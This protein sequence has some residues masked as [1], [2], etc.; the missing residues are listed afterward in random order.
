MGTELKKTIYYIVYLFIV[1]GIILCGFELVSYYLLTT[2]NKKTINKT[3]IIDPTLV[4]ASNPDINEFRDKLAE[5]GHQYEDGFTIYNAKDSVVDDKSRIKIL[6]L[7]GSTS[8]SIYYNQKRE[9][10]LNWPEYFARL[11]KEKGHNAIVINGSIAGYNSTQELLKL[12]RDG[13]E[14]SPD[15]IIEFG[16]L[17][18]IDSLAPLPYPMVLEHQRHIAKLT[19]NNMKDDSKASYFFMKNTI[20]LLKNTNKI[21]Y[22]LTYGKKSNNNHASAWLRN[23]RLMH[24]TASEI[25][26]GFCSILQPSAP[27]TAASREDEWKV[28][29]KELTILRDSQKIVSAKFPFIYDWTDMFSENGLNPANYQTDAEHHTDAGNQLIAERIYKLV[30]DDKKCFGSSYKP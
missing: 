14:F 13:L 18:E 8:D 10:L 19:L 26:A 25:G 3:M 4:W 2:S 20:A 15:I 7:G 9:S 30:F 21:D 1:V 29:V 27:I 28:H 17:R 16:G 23:I 11:I 12:L 6:I 22:S 24:A 5:R